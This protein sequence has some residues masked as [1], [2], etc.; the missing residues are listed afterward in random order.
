MFNIRFLSLGL[1][2]ALL[3]ACTSAKM[4]DERQSTTLR[5]VDNFVL[6]DANLEAHEL[7]RMSDAS[8][9][10]LVTQ[11]NGC[12]I[13][14]GLTPLLV[15]LKEK[16]GE[17]GVQVFL[18][19]STLHDS[20][21]DILAEAAEFKFPVPVLMD[22]QQLIG[23][24]LGVTRTAEA[25]VIDPK[26]WR[27]VYHGPLTDGP[28]YGGQRAPRRHFVD[29]SIEAIL[30]GGAPPQDAP[31]AMGCL[32]NFPE[33]DRAGGPRQLSYVRDV[34]P[35]L[36]ENCVQC[37][38][39]GGVAPW[40][41]RDY[42]T[43]RGF[44]PMIREVLRTKRMPPWGADPHVG[45]FR[46]DRS[47]SDDQ[48]KAIV[49]WIEAGSPRGDGAD[50][51][52]KVQIVEEEWP[53]GKP[54]LVLD[55]PAFTVPATG[56]IDY[57]RPYIANPMKEAK[58]LRATTIKVGDTRAV[59]HMLAGYMPSIPADGKALETR[60]KHFV[61]GYAVG[62]ESTILPPGAGVY[63]PAG[64]AIGVQAH[65]T[66]FGKSVVDR[67]RIAL[68]FHKVPPEWAMQS[69][70]IADLSLAIPPYA[71]R[72]DETAYL[73]FP[74]DALLYGAFP[75]AHYRGYAA[76]LIMKPQNSEPQLLLRLPRYD[77]NWQ[78][79][80]DFERPVEIP[81]GTKMIARFTYD[82]SD[83]N[84]ANPD[85]AREIRWGE[86]SNDEMLFMAILYRWKGASVTDDAMN[87]RLNSTPFM[88]ML[89]DNLD[90]SLERD[91]LRG[92]I[93]EQL[94]KF[95]VQLDRDRNG[96]LSLQEVGVAERIAGAT[97][98]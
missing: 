36:I 43:V 71:Q 57:Q 87:S 33:R 31:A 45:T 4:P 27:V 65:Y 78:R 89:D 15:A 72:H 29:E 62:A 64:G 5:N 97:T 18:L 3:V 11:A 55:V 6:V 79:M 88:S 69:A 73:T 56:V 21:E 66:P 23:E 96:Q 44:A 95:F 1:A 86:Q 77:F 7:Y 63:L 92:A 9:I 40:A 58:W 24:S 30:S 25:F 80:Y 38:R 48:V 50:P 83:S 75:H 59:H 10:V 60:W 49:H 42:E 20:R 76:S 12:P 47:L 28:V 34:A 61:G 51:L 22:S 82:N 35:L 98:P 70:V 67:T 53:L 52:L 85:P 41:M 19:N 26:S 14:R 16:Y 2:A 68:Y 81:A 8:A 46:G 74:A 13:V 84:P 37:H 39:Q 32:I 17:K 93:G 54:D 91:E 94:A 90:G